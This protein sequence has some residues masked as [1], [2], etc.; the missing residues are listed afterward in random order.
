MFVLYLFMTKNAPHSS[1]N[2]ESIPLDIDW[3]SLISENL[4][5]RAENQTLGAENQKLQRRLDQLSEYLRQ[6]RGQRFGR[7]SVNAS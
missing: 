7:S 2:L 3:K 4:S 5:L 6:E 1:K